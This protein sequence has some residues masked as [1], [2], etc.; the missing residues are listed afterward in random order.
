MKRLAILAACATVALGAA[1]AANAAPAKATFTSAG[2]PMELQPA[3]TANLCVTTAK[4]AP[5][6]TTLPK[7]SRIL[8]L[9]PYVDLKILTMSGI[10]E[11]RADWS[12]QGRD[13]MSTELQ[14]SMTTS[15][16]PFQSLT[17]ADA[18]EGHNGQLLRLHQAVGGSILAFTY[19]PLTLP[20]KKGSFDWTLGEGAKSLSDTYGADYALFTYVVGSYSSGG[21]K[22]AWLAVAALGASIPLGGQQAVASLV[23]LRTGQ[24]VWF[25]VTTAS[26]TADVRAATGA[27]SL[28]STLLKGMPL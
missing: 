15:G 22:I 21:R 10:A 1:G 2:A 19:S 16:H 8:V 6:I 24:I 25:N 4:T 5:G 12:A 7:G 18:M 26:P 28:M 20:T 27:H 17:A 13:N 14:G 23:D 9:T 11:P 3:D